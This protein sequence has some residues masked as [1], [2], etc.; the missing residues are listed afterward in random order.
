MFDQSVFPSILG[1]SSHWLIRDVNLTRKQNRL[2]ITVAAKAG[3][4][5]D[6]PICKGQAVTVSERETHWR[7]DNLFNLRARITAILPL[8]SCSKCGINRVLAPWEKQESRFVLL[9][10]DD[11]S[12]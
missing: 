3:T 7:H 11:D 2:D 1:L 4:P 6:C 12:H 5:F 9:D 8:T 10:G